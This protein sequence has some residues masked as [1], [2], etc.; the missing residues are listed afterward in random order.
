MPIARAVLLCAGTGSRMG[1]V[2]RQTP[3]C[4]LEVGG[5]TILDRQLDALE[6]SGIGERVVVAGH[7]AEA[8]RTAAGPRAEVVLNPDYA[9]TN[10]L[11]SL[12][13][14]VRGREPA[15][16]LLVLAGDVAFDPVI[17][18]DL[19]EARS[20]IRLAVDRS[21]KDEEAVKVRLRGTRVTQIGKELP[22]A[23]ADGEFLGLLA[24][25]GSAAMQIGARACTMTDR[26]ERDAYL[27]TML[28]QIL[29][30]GHL[31][32]DAIPVGRRR[33]EEVDTPED[34]TRARE[35]FEEGKR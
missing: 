21:R 35:R 3:K 20:P 24:A 25:D 8:I 13:C 26:G 18:G 32:I 5:R 22:I 12:A 31:A 6:A 7:L 17:L 30:E 23:D 19:L 29:Q 10:V 1:S 33:W 2:G 15:A 34:L 14:A 28:R 9:T 11:A 16:R 27:Y 4:L